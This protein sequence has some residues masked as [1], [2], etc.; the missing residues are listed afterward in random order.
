MYI[1]KLSLKQFGKFNNKDIQLE[2]G[3]NLVKCADEE[4]VDT[5]MDF[6]TGILYGIGKKRGF[7]ESPEA[8][9]RYSRDGYAEPAGKAYVTTDGEKY[10][11]EREFAR[12]NKSASVVSAKNG[13]ETALKYPNSFKGILFD[14]DRNSFRELKNI[15]LDAAPESGAGLADYA[16]RISK[17]AGACIR[18][19]KAVDSLKEQR[20]DF[21][22]SGMAVEIKKLQA[23]M[24]SYGDVEYDLESVRNDRINELQSY[25]MEI[26]RLKREA[27]NLVNEKNAVIPDEDDDRERE[28]IFLEVEAIPDEISEKEKI[29]NNPFVIIGAGVA[30]VAIVTLFSIILGFQNSIRQLFVICSIVFVAVTIIDGMVRKGFFEGADTPDEEDFEKVVYELGRTTESRTVRIEIDKKFQDDHDDKIAE[31]KEAEAVLVKKRDE[32]NKL[33]T[34][35]DELLK[36]Y[37]EYDTEKKAIDQAIEKITAISSSIEREVSAKIHADMSAILSRLSGGSLRDIY[38]TGRYAKEDST[39]TV[40]N[41][42][43]MADGAFVVDGG[44]VV[45]DYDRL[46][47]KDKLMVC[48]A[49]KI[50]CSGAVIKE[51]M[52]VVIADRG[53]RFGTPFVD[54]LLELLLEKEEQV[55]YYRGGTHAS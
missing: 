50:A 15:D 28:R 55:I 54:S 9:R 26:A 37:Q 40:G 5:L 48:M 13:I 44:G 47:N 6:T 36:K 51:K 17:S 46:N 23:E 49:V 21:D 41:A 24:N 38:F 53:D 14:T 25:N 16:D 7:A 18:A 20:Q 31:L 8:Y 1:N 22:N 19:D 39:G 2:T 27:R 43:A 3:I 4:E 11:I 35:R 29:Q 34:R 10:L 33:K 52:P 32:Y 12:N 42:C 45:K 30:V